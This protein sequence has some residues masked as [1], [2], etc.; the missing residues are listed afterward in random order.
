MSHRAVRVVLVVLLVALAG[1]ASPPSGSTNP[2]Q[3]PTPTDAPDRST[4]TVRDTAADQ[5]TNPTPSPVP[6]TPSPQSTT[7]VIEKEAPN[8]DETLTAGEIW[9]NLERDD[10][11]RNLDVVE[12][13]QN[14]ST[15][16]ITYK[17]DTEDVGEFAQEVALVAGAYAQYLE[18]GGSKEILNV[19]VV[20]SFGDPRGGYYVDG[21]WAKT[22][23]SGDVEFSD[24]V[25]K[26]LDE[27]GLP[28]PRGY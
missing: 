20:D 7:Q 16:Q 13:T 23:N 27:N 12:M 14:E 2:T 28:R 11:E 25:I 17:S 19:T 15:L 9:Y 5:T 10:A 6:A 22:Y 21:S 18:T 3:T 1:C 8:G 26:V 24:Y 4:D